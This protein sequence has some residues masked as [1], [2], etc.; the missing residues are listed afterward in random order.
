MGPRPPMQQW[1]Q[2]GP[3]QYQPW[4]NMGSRPNQQWANMGSQEMNQSWVNMGPPQGGMAYNQGIPERERKRRQQEINGPLPFT[5][6][7]NLLHA[8]SADFQMSA[9]IAKEFHRHFGQPQILC[10]EKGV[11]GDVAIFNNGSRYIFHLITKPKYFQKPN[12]LHL[13]WTLNQLR[14]ICIQERIEKICMSRIGCGLDGLFW[15]GTVKPLLIK[16]LRTIM[17]DCCH[18]D[19][20]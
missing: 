7:K 18:G 16:I 13:Q 9:G 5:S 4:I 19:V 2:M 10:C 11:V 14:T 1:P 6:K 17:E 8:V 20:S 12:P 3:H 15:H